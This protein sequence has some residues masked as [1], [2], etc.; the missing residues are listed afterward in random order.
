MKEDSGV[1]EKIKSYRELF[2][3]SHPPEVRQNLKDNEFYAWLKHNGL[4]YSEFLFS[5][6][7]APDIHFKV[8]LKAILYKKRK[9]N[10][11]DECR[12]VFY[13]YCTNIY[14]S[15]QYTTTLYAKRWG[16]E[17]GYC[18]ID[19]FEGFTTTRQIIPR[20]LLYGIGMILVNL[21]LLL[22][23]LL[24]QSNL[25]NV[26]ITRVLTTI[27]IRRSHQLITTGK[28]FLRLIRKH[29]VEKEEEVFLYYDAEVILCNIF[30]PE[31]YF[32]VIQMQRP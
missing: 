28:K 9:L 18:F 20:I 7:S 5:Y 22:N 4:I 1:K 31:P 16:I 30:L 29:W 17:T 2:L 14:A 3:S 19:R 24:N 13:S 12:V 6:N 25:L 21:W 8:I 32:F 11:D 15:L 23:S 26:L 27:P 10:R